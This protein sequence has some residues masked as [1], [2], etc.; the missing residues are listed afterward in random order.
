[1]FA[2]D[3]HGDGG[4]AHGDGGTAERTRYVGVELARYGA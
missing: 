3:A 2:Y 1:M 4:T